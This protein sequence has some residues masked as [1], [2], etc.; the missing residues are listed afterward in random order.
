[1]D[2]YGFTNYWLF[3]QLFVIE[4]MFNINFTRLPVI[5]PWPWS[6]VYATILS[7]M[8]HYL[9]FVTHVLIS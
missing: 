5:F 2:G 3:L 8:E 4:N 7:I 9:Y 1:M 6:M